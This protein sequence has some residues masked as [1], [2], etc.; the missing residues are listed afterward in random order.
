MLCR[1]GDTQAVVTDVEFPEASGGHKVG[2][3]E[4][5]RAWPVGRLRF[6][7]QEN[8]Y[9]ADAGVKANGNLVVLRHDHPT[10]ALS[11]SLRWR[12]PAG[13]L[14]PATENWRAQV[15][16][17]LEADSRKHLLPK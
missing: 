8:S 12:D 7:G 11:R 17:K 9:E 10:V 15:L 1:P 2:R 13:N 16:A 3:A 14:R 4:V 6:W 5:Y